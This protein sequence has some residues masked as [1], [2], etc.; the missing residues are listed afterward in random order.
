MMC[1]R[2]T[3]RLGTLGILAVGLALVAP[4]PADA[5]FLP[6]LTVTPQADFAINEGDSAQV[7]FTVFNGTGVNLILDYALATITH[8]GPDTDDFINFSG[9][10]GA[11]GLANGPLSIL[12]G[13]TAVF[14]YNVTSPGD[15]EPGPVDFGLDPV[16][17]SIEMSELLGNPPV[18]LPALSGLQGLLVIFDSPPAPINAGVLAGLNNFQDPNA[19]NDFCNPASP[20]FNQPTTYF[21]STQSNVA[22]GCPNPAVT[23][24]RVNDVPEPA[25]LAIFGAALGLLGGRR[26]A[27]RRNTAA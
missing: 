7:S 18:V 10:G 1:D 25:S 20:T 21:D 12:N 9:A 23:T 13:G 14:R 24:V 27:R 4:T 19:N 17:F 6:G 3:A 22:V 5:A 26:V 11:N 2:M 8:G 16:S 15:L